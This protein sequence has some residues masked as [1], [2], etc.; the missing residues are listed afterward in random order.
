MTNDSKLT[1]DDVRHIALLARIGMTDE[2]V[3]NMRN[4]LS[5]IMDQFDALTQVD[6]EGV[7]PTGHSVDVTSVMRD[8][9]SR[10]SLP[11]EDVLANAPNREDDRIRVKAVM[12]HTE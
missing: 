3:Q 4:D 11:K 5:N 1:S 9:V 7:E 12:E 10:P 6:T 8:D 2:D